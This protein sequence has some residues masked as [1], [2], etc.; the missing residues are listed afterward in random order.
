MNIMYD[1][2]AIC[3]AIEQHKIPENGWCVYIL[4]YGNAVNDDENP[5][6]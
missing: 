1:K 5:F 4:E 6:L 3:G 2:F